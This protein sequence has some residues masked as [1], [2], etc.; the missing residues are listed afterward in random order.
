MTKNNVRK[1]EFRY[2]FK[3]SIMV[4]EELQSEQEAKRQNRKW[5]RLQSAQYSVY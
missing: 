2:G 1:E 4:G 3:E 5:V